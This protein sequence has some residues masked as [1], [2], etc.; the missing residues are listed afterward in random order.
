M[1][2]LATPVPVPPR[3]RRMAW[4]KAAGFTPFVAYRLLLA[5]VLALALGSGWI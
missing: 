4:L 1:T 3:G 2:A 5:A